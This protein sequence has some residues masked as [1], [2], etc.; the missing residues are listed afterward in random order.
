MKKAVVLTNKEA[1]NIMHVF[2]DL[3]W[4]SEHCK[5]VDDL[6]KVVDKNIEL[7]TSVCIDKLES[8]YAIQSD[9]P[10]YD[11]EYKQFVNRVLDEYEEFEAKKLI[12]VENV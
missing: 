3:I 9:A 2:Y 8:K 10:D 12:K 11:E 1:S 5:N 7:L 6:R 4:A